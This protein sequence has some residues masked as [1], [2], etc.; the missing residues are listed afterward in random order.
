MTHELGRDAAAAVAWD[1]LPAAN[2]AEACCCLRLDAVARRWQYSVASSGTACKIRRPWAT[3]GHGA[4][5][6]AAPR[7]N[8]VQAKTKSAQMSTP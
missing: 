2:A 5:S 1:D 6:G 3:A 4:A 8:D 7:R